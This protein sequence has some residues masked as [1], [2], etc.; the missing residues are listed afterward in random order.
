MLRKYGA[1]LA[2]FAVGLALLAGLLFSVRRPKPAPPPISIPAPAQPAPAAPK[3]VVLQ[4]RVEA[5]H[6]IPVSVSIA[7]EIDTFS[8]DV[9]QDVYEGQIIARISNQGLEV[10]RDNAQRVLQNAEAKLNT[11]ETTISAARLEAVR[12]HDDAARARDDLDRTTKAYQRQKMLQG[13]G[14]TPRNTYEKSA[15]DYEAAQNDSD[16]TAELARHADERVE[17]LTREYD[18]TKKTLEDKR[19]E[20]EEVQAAIV[21]TEVHAP[22]AGVVVARQGDIGKTITQQE[23]A[24]LFSI[25][26][27]ITALRAV[28]TPDPV[29][30]PGDTVFVSVGEVPG[31][32]LPAVIR[33]IK[34]GE[35]KAEFTSSNP[36][37]RPGMTCSVHVR[38]KVR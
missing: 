23:A 34:G 26:A 33:E 3:D 18:L 24:A 30:K 32:P 27:D 9:G 5:Q 25:A 37:I 38:P 35:A 8:A 28:F 31:D 21:A 10:G 12:A 4:G 1:P 19:K 29:L 15:K 2:G 17:S 11:L 20:L 6:T 13:A 14:A 7:G 36:A 16:G 22:V